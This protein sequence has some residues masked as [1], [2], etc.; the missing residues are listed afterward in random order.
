LPID[1]DMS[2]T[3]LCCF[4]LLGDSASIVLPINTKM[5]I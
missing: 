2:V 1:G 5:T 4:A 3:L